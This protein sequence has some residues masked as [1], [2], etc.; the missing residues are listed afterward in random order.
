VQIRENKN[1]LYQDRER[2]ASR[3]EALELW[4]PHENLLLSEQNTLLSGSQPSPTHV[5]L[6][7][8]LE[9]LCLF[10]VSS[11]QIRSERV[12]NFFRGAYVWTC[13][14]YENNFLGKSDSNSTAGAS[15]ER[16]LE[17]P[18]NWG[19]RCSLTSK[20]LWHSGLHNSG[21]YW[22]KRAIPP[23]QVAKMAC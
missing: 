22:Q 12:E 7:I 6:R 8:I 3:F 2:S 20:S 9:T 18:R 19:R 15:Q 13:V 14:A 16:R 10:S 17:L 4:Y 21:I 11:V 5:V 1:F 23:E